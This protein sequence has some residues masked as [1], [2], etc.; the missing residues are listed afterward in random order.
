[1][2]TVRQL[3]PDDA[4]A[5]VALRR[6]MLQDS[7]WAY[8]ASP[9]HDRGS[10]LTL[11]KETLGRPDRA[12]IAAVHQRQL[13]AAAGVSREDLPK[14]RHLAIM[15][16][17]YVTPGARGRGLGRAVVEGAIEAAHAW[18]GIAGLRLSV[19]AN[20]PVAERLYE[21]LGFRAWGREPDALRIA[22]VG[23]AEVH[24][25]LPISAPAL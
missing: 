11:V 23:Y 4:D 15:W 22:G 12:I 1:M 14:R 17:V 10:D 19:S 25:Y 9:G 6:E 7:P 16:G 24:M 2:H 18:Q 20:A 8:L 21:S 3:V 5:Y 13:I